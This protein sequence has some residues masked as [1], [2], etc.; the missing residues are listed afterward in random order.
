MLGPLGDLSW[1]FRRKLSVGL[2]VVR[3]GSMVRT[4]A[5]GPV[6]P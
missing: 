4:I 1:S 2:R 3:V 6:G 5:Q